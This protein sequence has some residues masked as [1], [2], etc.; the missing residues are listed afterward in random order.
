MS[1]ILQ[2][3]KKYA[4]K[5]IDIRRWIHA[6]P[7]LGSQEVQTCDLVE[8]EPLSMDIEVQRGIAVTGLIGIIHGKKGPGKTIMIRADMDALPMEELGDCP[9]RSQNTGIA[10]MCGHDAHTAAV[11][12]AARI[13]SQIRDEFPGTVKLCF[14]PAEEAASGG[15]QAMVTE[16]LLENPH[17][18]F[19]IGMHVTPS[20]PVG[21]AA[22]EPGPITSYP[23]FFSI[24]FHGK[25]GHGSFPSKANDPILPMV[26]AYQMIMGI[27]KR[28]SPLEPA[29]VQVC[30]LSS[31]SAEAVIP[32]S[33]KILGTVRTLHE[34][35]RTIV[36]DELERIARHVA[37]IYQVKAE[38]N[39]RG[40]CFPVYNDPQMVPFVQKSVQSI[41]DKGFFQDETMKI[42]G[43][44]YCFISE[45][46][47]SV[48]LIVGSSDGTPRTQ[49]PVHNPYFDLDESVIEKC[50]AAFAKITLDYLDGRYEIVDNEQT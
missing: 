35:N 17:V 32:D 8:R 16:G 43:E 20:K 38:F 47:P 10:H 21:Y 44:D 42:G 15:A 19:S 37:E 25:G 11:I 46:V 29:V 48:F 33:A 30:T 12:G 24:V 23:D 9:Y 18:D 45:K 28:V 27:S 49:F 36:K 5:Q 1:D 6:H 41:F 3:A 22:I 26:E 4:Q 13:L 31:G 50:S 39:Y 40:R 14:Q 2:L 34:H 7:E